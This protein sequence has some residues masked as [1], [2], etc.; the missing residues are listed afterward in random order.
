MGARL[1]ICATPHPRCAS[2]AL[3]ERCRPSA[4][5]AG[6]RIEVA[7]LVTALLLECLIGCRA[8]PDTLERADSSISSATPP[9]RQPTVIDGSAAPFDAGSD[10]V[11]LGADASV[12]SF[13]TSQTT[14]AAGGQTIPPDVQR[15]FRM[16]APSILSCID[17]NTTPGLPHGTIHGAFRF[18]W[19]IG[20]DGRVADARIVYGAGHGEY[21]DNCALR[22]F[23]ALKF[24]PR[25]S[26]FDGTVTF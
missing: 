4:Q 26:A 22:R 16:A 6:N 17:E 2:S 3:D 21:V 18:A 20:A 10:P 24:P 1:K 25:S 11:G 5:G 19:A 23:R 15:V 9:A 13:D 8:S 12:G 14:D 7:V